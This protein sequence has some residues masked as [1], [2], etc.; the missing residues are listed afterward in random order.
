MPHPVVH[1]KLNPPQPPPGFL[2]R[3]RL[4][5]RLVDSGA[6][7]WLVRAPAGYG[8]TT[9]VRHATNELASLDPDTIVAW[10]TLDS[11]DDDPVRFWRHVAAAVQPAA[12][13]TT[14]DGGLDALLDL[15]APDT[16][17]EVVDR[18]LG[19]I[20]RRD[21]PTVLVLDDLHEVGAEAA[22]EPLHRVLASCPEA[23]TLVLVSR[24]RLE[25]PIARER[26]RGRLVELRAD[27]LAFSDDEADAVLGDAFADLPTT[28]LVERM[29]G[30]PAAIGLLGTPSMAEHA[31]SRLESALAEGDVAEIL[32]RE[33]VA[34]LAP[35]T[36]EFLIET[37]ILFDL[38][39]ELVDAVT[40]RPGGLA[41]LRELHRDQVFIHLV[42]ARTHTYRYHQILRDHL[43]RFAAELPAAARSGL[44]LR[45]AG[46][47]ALDDHPTDAIWHAVAA[48]RRDLALEIVLDNYLDFSQRGELHTVS[49]WLDVLGREWVLELPDL[50]L[51]AAWAD[52]NT[53]RHDLVEQ[54]ID[55]PL[56]E[57]VSSHDPDAA[58]EVDVATDRERINRLVQISTIRSHVARHRGDIDT[59]VSEGRRAVATLAGRNLVAA[60]AA[61]A[62]LGAATVLNA[63]PDIE[64]LSSAIN[65]G[66][67]AGI[68]SSIV[69][70]YSY[71]ALGA[72]TEPGRTDEANAL[73]D[74][75]L[76]YVT[77]PTLERF[78]QPAAA[79]LARSLAAVQA[80]R[81]ADA[82]TAVDRARLLA[83]LGTE[84][85]MSALVDAQQ[86]IITYRS[87]DAAAARQHLRRAEQAVTSSSGA[88]LADAVRRARNELRF[89][90]TT[91]STSPSGVEELSDRELAVVRLLPH[92][93]GRR[94]LAAQLFISENTLK[95]HLTSIRRKLR[96]RG[97]TDLVA[98]AR[99]LGLIDDQSGQAK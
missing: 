49:G 17:G 95:T 67:A 24:R 53:G 83:T 15:L 55:L 10:C 90:A 39:P 85:T 81:L 40:G 73:A 47:L 35:D 72:A 58:P 94:D 59:A 9:L 26:G 70:G 50:R 20:E 19:E 57:L 96:V 51:V 31:S 38:R 13:D 11:A 46:V 66:R 36:R 18:L 86:A 22:I 64:V 62:A 6:P 33:V 56:H 61:A 74:Q 60:S 27:D 54:W 77:S 91:A 2:A 32:T 44:H 75:A 5:R 89:A 93:L 42:D 4:V 68:D 25:L 45:A 29:A 69:M 79:Y 41:V 30:W 43:R 3:P 37:S 76:A 98:R 34:D 7:V 97:R 16:V 65:L 12:R 80:G 21:V 48:E 78:H 87:G 99:E 82:Q 84:S 88:L 14:T 1:A 92:G 63:E 28:A 8:K 23:L 71:L 52:L